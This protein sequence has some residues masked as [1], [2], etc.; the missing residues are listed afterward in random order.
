[1]LLGI[2]ATINTTI[3]IKLD[4]FDDQ[5]TSASKSVN[6]IANNV[7]NITY[8]DNDGTICEIVGK[9]YS[10][11]QVDSANY[12]EDANYFIRYNDTE[13]IGFNENIYISSDTSS[14]YSLETITKQEVEL[15]FDISENYSGEYKT[16]Y[17]SRLRD[18]TLVN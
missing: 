18:A 9:L 6:L 13:Q 15:V 10:L 5:S 7:Y 16:V 14:F 3:V 11:K 17:L 8:F 2:A 4:F 1:M 12:V